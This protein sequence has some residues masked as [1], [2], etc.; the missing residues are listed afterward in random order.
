MQRSST[1]Q[2]PNDHEG[3]RGSPELQAIVAEMNNVVTVIAG[4]AELLAREQ[5]PQVIGSILQSVTRYKALSQRLHR[6]L[7]CSG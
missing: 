5:K 2:T 6:E 1:E 7:D 4:Y 3:G